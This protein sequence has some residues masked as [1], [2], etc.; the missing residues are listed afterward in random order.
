[1]DLTVGRSSAKFVSGRIKYPLFP[2]NTVDAS[3]MTVVKVFEVYRH[4]L[5]F[6]N[7]SSNII[8]LL[9]DSV[10]K[11]LEIK[12]EQADLEII[13]PSLSGFLGALFMLKCKSIIRFNEESVLNRILL[14]FRSLFFCSVWHY[15]SSE[16]LWNIVYSVHVLYMKVGLLFECDFRKTILRVY[17]TRQTIQSSLFLE[18][19][20]PLCLVISITRM[21]HT[22]KLL[23]R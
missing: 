7:L 1:M 22:S 8:C 18:S 4:V 5:E 10:S 15:L 13:A 12:F 21:C 2:G 3:P 17:V 6:P 23:S 14:L 20:I 9:V 16:D 19:F 11:L